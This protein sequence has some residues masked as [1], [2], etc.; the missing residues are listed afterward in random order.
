MARPGAPSSSTAA[1]AGVWLNG[2]EYVLQPTTGTSNLNQWVHWALSRD[3]STLTLYRNGV[4]IAQRI[5]LP[6]S[7]SANLSGTIG[8]QAGGSYPLTG[9]VDEV[10]VYTGVRSGTD[11]AAD[12]AAALNGLASSGPVAP[13]AS[14]R[15]TVLRE[16]SLADYWRLGETS[17]TTAA[18]SKGSAAGTYANTTLGVTPTGI[19]ND[20]NP[21]AGFNGT[22]S[23][24]TV[25]AT[26]P[27]AAGDFTI[28]GWTYL[29]N[30][31]STNNTLFGANGTVRLLARP[32]NAGT[33]TAAYAGVW[34]GGTEYVLQPNSPASNVNTWVHWVLTRQGSTLTLYRNGAQIGQRTDLPATATANLNGAI[35]MQQGTAYPLAGTI[36]DVAVYTGALS[37][38][39]VSAHYRAALSGP[40]PQ[41]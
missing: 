17:G 14:Y 25:P 19:A 12:Y 36:D 3:G 35:G 37:A 24:V 16:G 21:A 38:T 22:N 18:D 40:A 7:A 13:G 33:P 28:E 23:R 34:L 5:D 10:A 1:Y 31:S 8:N 41:A 11:L 32:G 26:L 15:D 2:T 39:A 4:A 29:T 20:A 9:S 27:A 30:A 6:A